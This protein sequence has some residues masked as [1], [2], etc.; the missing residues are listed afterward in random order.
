MK[1]VFAIISFVFCVPLS[2]GNIPEGRKVSLLF[3]RITCVSQ[4]ELYNTL[5]KCISSTNFCS[6]FS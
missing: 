3:F 1:L 5:A 4:I 6:H 2:E